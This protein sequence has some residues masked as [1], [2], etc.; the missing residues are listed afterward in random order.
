MKLYKEYTKFIFDIMIQLW[1]Q[2][3]KYDLGR[4]MGK[5]IKMGI[6]EKIKVTNKKNWVKQHFSMI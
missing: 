1:Y 5:I 2:I 6:S 4:K 3:M